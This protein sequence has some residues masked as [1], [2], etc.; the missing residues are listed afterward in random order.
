MLLPLELLLIV[1]T[2]SACKTLGA[3]MG[4]LTRTWHVPAGSL[5]LNPAHHGKSFN[6]V[7]A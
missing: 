2:W 5:P 4:T 7:R 6:S 1:P 3:E